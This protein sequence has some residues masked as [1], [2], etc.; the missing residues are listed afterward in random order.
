M[1]FWVLAVPTPQEDLGGMGTA[2]MVSPRGCQRFKGETLR[3]WRW[4]DLLKN[5]ALPPTSGVT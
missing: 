1:D 3:L 5:P 2:P 4:R